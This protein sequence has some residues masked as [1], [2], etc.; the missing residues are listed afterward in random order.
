MKSQH[1]MIV[2]LAG[3]GLL[4][5][6]VW[7]DLA[8]EL[9]GA[10]SAELTERPDRLPE[11]S[12]EGPRGAIPATRPN[13][14]VLTQDYPQ[15]ALNGDIEGQTGF[16]VSISPFGEVTSCKITKPSGYLEF[17][18]RVC[19]AISTRA[20]FYPALNRNDLPT[21]GTYS[22]RVVWRLVD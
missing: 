8:S 2:A 16:T 1:K 21:D 18:D 20:K 4:M 3:I 6:A 10:K 15:M 14:W 22:S 11:P 5:F 19:S 9:F 12:M 17:D 7:A 13:S